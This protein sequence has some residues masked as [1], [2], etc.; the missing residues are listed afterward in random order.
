MANEPI[1]QVFDVPAEFQK[2]AWI[3]SME[4]YQEMYRRS[5]DDADNFWGEEAEKRLTWI[6]KWDY[7]QNHDFKNAKIRWF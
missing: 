2:D 1:E 5:L 7:V 6:K 4:Q 3:S